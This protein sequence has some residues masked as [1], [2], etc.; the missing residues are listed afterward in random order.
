MITEEKVT[1]T[2][3]NKEG[4]PFTGCLPETI[5]EAIEIY[6]D[7]GSLILLCQGLRVSQARVAKDKWQQGAT[8]EEVDQAVRD[9]RPGRKSKASVAKIAAS[10]L[11]EHGPR[12]Q[13]DPE[14]FE[15]AMELFQKNKHS[16]LVEYLKAR[17]G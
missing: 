12:I 4:W 3:G 13:A 9:F 16:E 1:K 7:E 11:V 14:L 10:M 15:T 5:D 8:R 6:G 17:L 2:K